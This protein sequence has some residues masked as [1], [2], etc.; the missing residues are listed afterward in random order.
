MISNRQADLDQGRIETRTLGEITSIN[1]A[2][3]YAAIFPNAPA[4]DSGQLN[5]LG[6]TRRMQVAA[7]LIRDYADDEVFDTL[8]GHH[9]DTAR[10]WAAYLVGDKAGLTLQERLA[11][12]RPFADDPHFGVR[13][14]AWLAVRPHV[15]ADIDQSLAL[16]EP[17]V[18]EMSAN[19]RRFAIEVTRPRGVWSPHIR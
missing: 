15:A 8:A 2:T 9:S 14:W 3:L 16:L 11:K 19:L 18:R 7:G 4:E 17:W 6:I 10:G 1:H 5:Q 12:V 13:E